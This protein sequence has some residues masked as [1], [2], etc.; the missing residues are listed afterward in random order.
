[1]AEIF[2]GVQLWNNTTVNITRTGLL[3]MHCLMCNVIFTLH[4]WHT[5]FSSWK[6]RLFSVAVCW[7]CAGCFIVLMWFYMVLINLNLSFESTVSIIVPKICFDHH[8]K[9]I[10]HFTCWIETNKMNKINKRIR[11]CHCYFNF[12]NHLQNII[13]NIMF[14]MYFY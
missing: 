10:V 3:S 13:Q 11:I 6:L 2:S 5:D 8:N 1:M 9:C 4:T 14:I 7:V 12:F